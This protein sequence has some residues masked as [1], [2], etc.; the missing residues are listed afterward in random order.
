MLGHSNL[1]SSMVVVVTQLTLSTSIPHPVQSGANDQA[2]VTEAP[3]H[4]GAISQRCSGTA[5]CHR[6]R[7]FAEYCKALQVLLLA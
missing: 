4:D 2:A 6:T 7:V 3:G 5:Q 1:R